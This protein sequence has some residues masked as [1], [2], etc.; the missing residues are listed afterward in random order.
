M[1]KNEY[2]L[3]KIFNP[4]ALKIIEFFLKKNEEG[5]NK[6]YNLSEFAEEAGISK[7]AL[8]KTI[9]NLEENGII[10]SKEV[11]VNGGYAKIIEIDWENELVYYLMN[12]FSAFLKFKERYSKK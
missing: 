5:E 9:K 10:I 7:G 8:S 12:S 1:R 3:P 2:I 11:P 4:T 6:K